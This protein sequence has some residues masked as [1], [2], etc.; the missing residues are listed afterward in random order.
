MV[1][2]LQFH[3]A[4]LL[5]LL[6]CYIKFCCCGTTMCNIGDRPVAIA[7]THQFMTLQQVTE[8]FVLYFTGQT[9]SLIPMQ[10]NIKHFVCVMMGELY[11]KSHALYYLK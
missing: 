11:G 3:H 8:L 5:A 9:S 2:R 4:T 7:L 1:L 6:I 10:A